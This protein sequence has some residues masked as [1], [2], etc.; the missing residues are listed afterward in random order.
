MRST[1]DIQKIKDLINSLCKDNTSIDKNVPRYLYH[2]TDIE[3]II[4]IVESGFLYSRNIAIRNE[5][6]KN[7]N[8]S[9]EVI[10]ITEDQNKDYVRLYF[11]PKTPTQYHNEG[12]KSEYKTYDN[13]AHCPVPVFLLFDSTE[14][15][16][17]SESKFTEKN[18][19]LRPT[20]KSEIDDLLNFDFTKIFHK[21]PIGG[22][23]DIIEKRH[24][25]VLI[26][27]KFDLK[28]LKLIIVRSLAEKETLLNILTKHDIN[29]N[30]FTISVDTRNI[31]F[32]KSRAYID[33]V[34]MENEYLKVGF[35]NFDTLT[36]NDKVLLRL[37]N[38]NGVR[39][40]EIKSLECKKAVRFN[41]GNSIDFYELEIY[42]NDKCVYLGKY[43]N[44][45]N[46]PF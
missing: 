24:A 17:S 9:Q 31:L 33:Y 42:V 35:T 8:A 2:F 3:N 43:Q 21:G 5:R 32:Y 38:Q 6:M 30:N 18:L 45:S 16:S 13:N 27:D 7:D 15:L 14:V 10:E 39:K 36:N 12:I 22:D 11:R 28:K 29:V 20:V 23:R 46:L 4:G 25:E 37:I 26:H 41:L 34:E 1:E 40:R 44:Q 19:A